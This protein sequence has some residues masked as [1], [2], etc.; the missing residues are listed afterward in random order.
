MKGY[1]AYINSTSRLWCV[2][3][4]DHEYYKCETITEVIFILITFFFWEGIVLPQD[5]IVLDLK[6]D[7]WLRL[8]GFS[9]GLY[10]LS[11][12]RCRAWGQY[13]ESPLSFALSVMTLSFNDWI[14]CHWLTLSKLSGW[15]TP[16]KHKTFVYYL[17]NVG[18]TSTT[19]GRRCFSS[20]GP[21]HMRRWTNA[22]SML[23]RRR[24]RRSYIHPALVQ[25]LSRL[26]VYIPHTMTRHITFF[27][28]DFQYQVHFLRR[29]EICG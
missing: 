27:I 14:V 13:L 4:N 29:A 20:A 15:L 24:R 2:L 9:R 7:K 23:G 26:L 10:D 21:R 16:S 12:V 6:P 5:Q 1:R 25:R 17:Y 18:P 28:D 8:S 19:L 22:G 3:I 11:L